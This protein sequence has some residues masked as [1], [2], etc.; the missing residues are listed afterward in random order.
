MSGPSKHWRTQEAEKP[1]ERKEWRTKEYVYVLG[2]YG[3]S[4]EKG[5]ERPTAWGNQRWT[6]VIDMRDDVTE[7]FHFGAVQNQ[8]RRYTIGLNSHVSKLV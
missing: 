5:S 2:I 4:G 6:K 8:K 1:Q 7:V 3:E